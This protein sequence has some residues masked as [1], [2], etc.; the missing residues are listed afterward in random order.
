MEIRH[1]DCDDSD[2]LDLMKLLDADLAEK[3]GDDHAFY[4]QF[5]RPAGLDPLVGY[6]DGNAVA[7]GAIKEIA[8]GVAEVKRMFTLP[9]YRGKGYASQILS[10]LEERAKACGLSECRLETGKKQV[11][12]I[13][14][15]LKNGYIVIPNYG[16][17]EGV[18]DSVCFRK[19]L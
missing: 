7:I 19:L 3:D 1:T 18:E 14:L 10:A 13:A 12:A 16:Q 15:Y 17:Y 6:V 8:P 5:N 4:A 9:E 2:F 11:D